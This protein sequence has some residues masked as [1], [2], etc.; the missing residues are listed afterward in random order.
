ML[1]S[2]ESF[3]QNSEEKSELELSI[4]ED[5]EKGYPYRYLALEGGGAKGFLYIGVARMLEKIGQL[6]DFEAVAGS[7]VGAIAA[8]LFATGWNSDKIGERLISLDLSKAIRGGIFSRLMAPIH[9][10]KYYGL[11][12]AKGLTRWLE[13]IVEEVTGNRLATYEDWHTL[14]EANL[15]RGLKD[16]F[17]EACNYNTKLNEIFSYL[18]EHKDVPIAHGIRA[19]A[20]FPFVFTPVEIKGSLYGD[21]G[22]QKNCPSTAFDEGSVANKKTLSIRLDDI[23]EINYFEK[24]IT[25]KA[26]KLNRP[27]KVFIAE[28]GALH[29][30]QNFWFNESEHKNNT[31][32]GDTLDAGTL[33]F[34]MSA[35]EIEGLI[36]SGE[37]AVIHYFIRNHSRYIEELIEKKFLDEKTVMRVQDGPVAFSEFVSGMKLK[38]MKKLENSINI[39]QPK[40]ELK[41]L[42]QQWR[43][44]PAFEHYGEKQEQALDESHVVH[45]KKSK[46]A[47][48]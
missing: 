31:I 37:Y 12:K 10:E 34:K 2:N 7:S 43:A 33:D 17:T 46:C 36:A 27:A 29:K 40:P 26:K 8:L 18:S 44:L 14:K 20:G 42:Y 22:I 9:V 5:F 11:H 48:M 21:G 23:E 41:W 13:D 24:G 47:I 30:G 39:E 19:S 1:G 28:I 38:Q 25:P 16:I 4:H 32:F 35:E 15:D 45:P 6:Q 3:E